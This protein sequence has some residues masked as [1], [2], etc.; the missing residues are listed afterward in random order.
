RRQKQQ[1]RSP[2]AHAAEEARAP[3][4]AATRPAATHPWRK[5]WSSRQQRQVAEARL[6]D[7]PVA[8]AA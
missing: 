6:A 3:S 1:P 2:I 5:P 8:S 7:A 4:E